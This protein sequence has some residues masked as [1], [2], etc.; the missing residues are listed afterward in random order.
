MSNETQLLLRTSGDERVPHR[1]YDQVLEA[2]SNLVL[3]DTPFPDE[4]LAHMRQMSQRRGHSIYAWNQETGLASLREH[5]ITVAGSKRM[6]E[7]VRF[8]LQSGHFGVYVFPADRSEYTPQ[9]M[10]LLRQIGRA[11]DGGKRILVLGTGI[12]VPALLPI[13]QSIVHKHGPS[14]R[15][16]LRDGRWIRG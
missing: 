10:A 4:L 9:V 15:L 11:K 1:L 16:R 13:S 5:G 12:N 8:V 6:A 3:L 7:A 14:D 2:T